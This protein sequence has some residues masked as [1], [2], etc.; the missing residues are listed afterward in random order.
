MENKTFIDIDDI[1]NKKITEQLENAM[2]DM[3]QIYERSV[4][5]YMLWEPVYKDYISKFS[6]SYLSGND[7]YI[8]D[9]LINTNANIFQKRNTLIFLKKYFINHPLG[10]KFK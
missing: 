7:I 10:P 2:N 5:E 8:G 9:S 4:T 1:E 6:K 3:E